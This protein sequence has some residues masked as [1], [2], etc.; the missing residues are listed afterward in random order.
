MQAKSSSGIG[1]AALVG[2]EYLMSHEMGNRDV[3]GT[4]T[5]SRL[6]MKLLHES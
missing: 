4:V 6:V 2:L 1:A 3:Y 5:H